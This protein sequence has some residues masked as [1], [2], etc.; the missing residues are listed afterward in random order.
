[1]YGEVNQSKEVKSSVTGNKATSLQVKVV[2][3]NLTSLLPVILVLISHMTP[4]PIS[5]VPVSLR[6]VKEYS[7]KNC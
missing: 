1:L 2:S 4:L 7:V 6:S 3:W 5:L